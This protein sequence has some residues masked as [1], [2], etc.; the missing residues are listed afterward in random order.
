MKRYSI[1]ASLLAIV[2]SWSLISGTAHGNS[3]VGAWAL[4]PVWDISPI[5]MLVLPNGKVMMYPGDFISG[6]DPRV[7][8]PTT[9]TLTALPKAGYDLFCSGHSFLADGT[10]LVTGGNLLTPYYGLPDASIYNPFTNLWTR[11][12]D[13]NAAR[14]YPSTTTMG[15]GN[16]LVM[17]GTIDGNHTE[18]PLPQ[19]WEPS[20]GTWRNLTNA[21]LKIY[22]YSWVYWTPLGKAIVA[23]PEPTT[24]YLNVS[25]TGAWSTL[26]SFNHSLTRDYGSSVLYSPY[27]ILIAGGGQPPTKTAEIINLDDTV[28]TWK[29]TN[30]MAF[31]RRHMNMTLLPDD[32]VL[33]TGGTSADGFDNHSQPVYAAEMWNRWTETWT[34]MA[35]QSVGR[36]YHSNALLLPDGRVLSAGG[37]GTGAGGYTYQTEIYSPPYLFKGARP[38]ITSAPAHINYGSSFFIATPEAASIF[39]VRLIRLPAVTHAFDQN[40]RILQVSF[41]ATTGGLNATAP[42][43]QDTTPPGHYMLF[44]LNTNDVPS[45]AKIIQIDSQ[46]ASPAPAA[47]TGLVATATSSSA[48][49]LTWA[50]QSNNE[51]GFKIERKVG[52]GSFTQIATVGTNVTAYANT[53]LTSSTT[54]SY[55]VRS[56]NSG[57]DSAYS[58]TASATTQA[59]APTIPA[60]PT[61]LTATATSS[62]AINVAWTDQSNNETGF[63]IERKVGTGSFT[64][65]ATVGANVTTYPDSGLTA[66]TGYS[67]RV[68]ATNSVGDSAYSN[69]ASATT[70]GAGTVPAAPS[71]LVAT[72]VSRTQ[73]NLTWVD[74][75]NNEDGFKIERKVGT[76]SFTQIATVGANVKTYSDT[77]LTRNTRY[78]YRV[79]AYNSVGNSGYSN[80]DS[81]KTNN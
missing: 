70:Q 27:R 47:P 65:V 41:S 25:G 54:Y 31:K 48:I 55:R 72:A 5:N 51:T 40:Q 52:T 4:G 53:G 76:G 14:W 71:G 35:S 8:D 29:Y 77:G 46:P 57:G 67:Y 56:T 36:F 73:I 50:D 13:M 79:R 7:W 10:I 80:N 62:T 3:M 2:A 61:G 64:Q 69:T 60:T 23:G 21:M 15:P 20:S 9:N 32:N 63:K 68:R 81:A 43:N 19:V 44:I 59:S 45:V 58:N 24:R 49:T 11:L 26:T 16:V 28:P 22:N 6:D 38:T 17:T 33:V 37:T 1:L 30:P 12:P 34:T 42:S 18:N 75:A 39:N 66:S 78:T 74:Q